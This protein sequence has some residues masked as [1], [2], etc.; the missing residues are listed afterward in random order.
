MQRSTRGGFGARWLAERLATLLSQYPHVALCVAF[1]GGADS[2]AL[3]AALAASRPRPRHLR[4]VHVDHGLHANAARWAAHCRS[5][6]RRLRVPLE[7]RAVRIEHTRGQSLEA[8][9]RAARY[10]ALEAELREG[11]V[12]LSAHHQDDQLETVL[13]QLL[14]GA[15][16]PGLAAMPELVRFGP[17]WLARPL[18]AVPREELVAW[19][20]EQHIEWIED[21]TNAEERIDR[22]YL[23]RRIVPLLRARW[24]GGARAVA[25]SARHAAEAQRLLDGL[26]RADLE[27][28]ACGAALSARALRTLPAERRRNALRY[29]IASRGAGAPDT[30]RLEEIAGALLA[31]RPDANPEVRWDGHCVRRQMDRLELAAPAARPAAL[32][33]LEWPLRRRRTLHLPDGLGTLELV[34]ATHGPIDRDALPAHVT[35]RF[36]T[37]GER[38]RLRADGPRRALKDLLQEAR[39]SPA[40]RARVPL[41]FAGERLLAVADRWVDASIR[42]TAATRR[43][44]RVGWRR[45]GLKA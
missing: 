33:A 37:G 38:L 29:W 19:L 25:R 23:R 41:L 28:A 26:A 39:I 6:A 27:R 24:P 3:L 43:R 18:L 10:A 20:C 17:G 45:E 31:A 1:S 36:R 13:L 4:A 14:R 15:G 7:V 11:E 42:A 21:D 16:L 9:A 40:E 30:R 44:V 32:P 35:V 12:L 5:V 8:A 34:A 2:T 22:N